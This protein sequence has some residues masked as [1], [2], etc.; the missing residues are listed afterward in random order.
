MKDIVT[1][2]TIKSR[3]AISTVSIMIVILAILS[4]CSSGGSAGSTNFADSTPIT[5]GASFSNSGDFADDGKAVEKGYRLWAQM[6]NNS[7]GILGRPVQLVILHDDSDPDHVAA[8]Y[9]TLIDKDHVDLV[10]GPFSTLLTKAAAIVADG[11]NASHKVYAFVEGSGGGPSVFDAHH[12]NLFSTSVPAV[13]NLATFADYILSLPE[14]LNGKPYRPAT[15]AYATS[16]DFFTQPQL[17]KAETIMVNGGIKTVFSNTGAGFPSDGQPYSADDPNYVT[18]F[19]PGV[20]QKI[21]DSKAQVVLLGTQFPDVIAY[22]NV[23]KKD[24][25]NPQAI[26]AT[27]GPDQGQDFIKAV[28]GVSYTQDIFVP[29]SWYPDAN[30][31]QNAQMVQAYLAQY[32]GSKYDINADVAEA[33]SV[34]QVLQQAITKIHSIDNTALINELH[35]DVF[36]GVQGPE[37]FPSDLYGQN[38]LALAY[39][40]QWQNGNFIPVYPS[41]AATGNPQFPKAANY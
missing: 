39:L 24:H 32:G 30:T 20:A 26:I 15:A 38:S 36:N 16:N 10:V 40:F 25:Y 8:N 12:E 1:R 17:Q 14:T 34:G 7:G 13:N 35:N 23:F 41:S 3:G 27:A 2:F 28:G 4:A 5:I 29:N 11:G 33:F 9:R 6:V 37:E 19:I 18:K 22:L 21:V 31:F